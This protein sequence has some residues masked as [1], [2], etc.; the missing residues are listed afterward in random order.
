MSVARNR[1]RQY[2][3]PIGFLPPLE[4]ARAKCAEHTEQARQW[5]VIVETLERLEANC[6]T[7]TELTDTDVDE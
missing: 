1:T 5:S 3:D 6:A 7:S 2:T 4:I